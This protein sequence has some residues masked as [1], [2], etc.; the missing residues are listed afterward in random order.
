MRRWKKAAILLALAAF[1]VA[2]VWILLPSGPLPPGTTGPDEPAPPPRREPVSPVDEPAV[3]GPPRSAP[4]AGLPSPEPRPG[5]RIVLF[6]AAPRPGELP[7][8]AR[9][10]L[11]ERRA[12]LGLD[13]MPG[14]LR[15]KREFASLGGW[16]LRFE[17]VVDGA[18]VFGSEVSVHLAPDGR[19]LLLNADIYPVQGVASAPEV[20]ASAAL[21]A[22]RELLLDENVDD[23]VEDDDADERSLALTARD[24]ELVILPEGRGGRLAWLVDAVTDDESTRTFV[25]AVTGEPVRTMNMRRTVDGLARVFVPN[26]AYSR[27]D[28]RL[29]DQNDIDQVVLTNARQLVT[30]H[31]LDETGRVRGQWCDT[32]VSDQPAFSTSRT[33]TGY[34]RGQIEFEQLNCYHHVD[35]VQDRLQGLGVFN[36]NASQQTCNVHALVADQSFYDVISDVVKFGDGGVDDAEDGDIVVHEYGHAIQFDQVQDFGLTGEGGALGEG[37]GDFLAALMHRTGDTEWDPLVATWDAVSYSRAAIP[38]LRRVDNDK[39]YPQDIQGLVHDDGEIWSRFLW[40]LVPLLGEDDTLR[41]VVESHFLLTPQA[42]FRDNA[43]ALLVTNIAIR[44][45]EHDATIRALLDERGIPFSSPPPPPPDEDAFEQNDTLGT[46]APLDPGTYPLLLADEDWFRLAVPANRRLHVHAIFEPAAVELALELRDASGAILGSS[47][48]LDSPSTLAVSAGPLGEEVFLRVHD[49]SAGI[50][51]GGYVL[52]VTE[53]ALETLQL[54]ATVL[55]DPSSSRNAVFRVPVDAEKVA[56]GDRV[57]VLSKRVGRRG[58]RSDLRITDP[59]GEPVSDFGD[60][61]KAKGAKVVFL[62][63][64]PGDWIVEVRPRDA[65]DGPYKLK[66]RLKR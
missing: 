18:R 22:V 43:N 61:R 55:I 25:D 41:L 9:E 13:G 64:R 52:T 48:T 60:G 58:A 46:A 53:T 10:V 38:H 32:A 30:L 35:R 23:G 21:D 12:E 51:A 28:A 65:R 29:K 56:A 49:T 8:V 59:A 37:F 2:A 40:D 36:A 26:P 50:G 19:P 1:S 57:K 16:H 4:P 66:V 47:Q 45:G 20:S 24:P 15:V 14:E 27:R 62:P 31:R 34:T 5:R 33:F 63:G 7:D 44:A 42:K 39:H 3:A 17:Q 11:E 6:D 54:G